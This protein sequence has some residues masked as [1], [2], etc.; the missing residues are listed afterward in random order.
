MSSLTQA[1]HSL[2]ERT[3][4]LLFPATCVA[5]RRHVVQ[6]GS[7][8]GACWPNLTLLERPWCAVLG[9]PFQTD[10]GPDAVSPAAIADPPPFRRLRAAVAFTGP[11]RD[12]VHAL[13]YRDRT[14]LARWMAV[15]MARAGSEL[16]ADTDLVAAVPLHRIRLLTRRFNQSA[17]LAR[18]VSARTGLPFLP[19]VVQRR[20]ATR[21]QVG[22]KPAE[23]QT[24]V[25][26]AFAVRP[27]DAMAI[28]GRR[29]LLVDDVYT[30][31]AT[32]SAVA[33]VLLRAGASSVDVLTFARVL[34]GDFLAG[35]ELTI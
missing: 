32:V 16:I 9:T 8:C 17:E 7:V 23:R 3:A 28:A 34:P 25:R 35:D 4:R 24:N 33:R 29:V 31:G 18:S 10:Y 5:C 14:D 27:Q 20:K 26:G 12:L 15:W 1:L 30:T 21:R 13:K 11:A 2:T 19:D 22:L 6:P